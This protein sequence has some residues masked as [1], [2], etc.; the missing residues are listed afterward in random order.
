MRFLPYL[1]GIEINVSNA[2]VSNVSRFYPTYEEL[3]YQTESF[4]NHVYIPFLPYLWGIEI[5]HIYKFSDRQPCFYPTYEELKFPLRK[6]K[7]SST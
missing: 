7:V 1:W 5:S 2:V 4:S 6:E 3:K